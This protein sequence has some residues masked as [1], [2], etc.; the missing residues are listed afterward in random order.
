MFC[1]TY[2]LQGTGRIYYA[3]KINPEATVSIVLMLRM[4]SYMHSP[5]VSSV[6]RLLNLCYNSYAK[7]TPPA[8]MVNMLYL[9]CD[10]GG[11]FDLLLM[12]LSINCIHIIWANRIGGGISPTRLYAEFMALHRILKNSKFKSESLIIV[13]A[14]YG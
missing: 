9:Q 10:S 13:K 11:V 8:I 3:D 7:F 4:I 12:W 14:L 5:N 2:S 1:T 6:W